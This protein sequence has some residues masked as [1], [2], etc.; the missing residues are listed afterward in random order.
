MFPMNRKVLS[1]PVTVEYTSRG[2][3]VRKTLP[4][5]FKARAFY[6]AKHKAGKKPE[7]VAREVSFPLLRIG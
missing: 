2:K 4:D 1:A 5:S 6:A 7:V 3:R